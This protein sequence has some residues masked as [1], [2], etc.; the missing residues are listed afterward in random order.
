MKPLL[1]LAV[2]TSL[3]TAGPA[4]AKA[5]HWR[6]PAQPQREIACT[7]IGCVPVPPGCWQRPA[8]SW[9]GEP[10]GMDLIVCPP[11]VAPFR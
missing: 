2:V 11:G 4:L 10:L 5:R 1:A 8:R 6:A 3:L 7:M 9:T